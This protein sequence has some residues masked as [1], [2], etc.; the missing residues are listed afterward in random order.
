M[1]WTKTAV[2]VALRDIANKVNDAAIAYEMLSNLMKDRQEAVQAVVEKRKP[3][4][5]GE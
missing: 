2:N 1:R 3:S 4:Y 5:T